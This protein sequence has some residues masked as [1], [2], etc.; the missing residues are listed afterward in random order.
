MIGGGERQDTKPPGF[1]SLS[2]TRPPG[3]DL[4]AITSCRIKWLDQLRFRSAA[5]RIAVRVR[6]LLF[7][8]TRR[9][10]TALGYRAGMWR[11]TSTSKRPEKISTTA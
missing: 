11:G 5:M 7:P 10:D 9:V 2:V 8:H 4:S 1:P 6:V 3:K